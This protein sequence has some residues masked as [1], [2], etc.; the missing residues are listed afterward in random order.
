MIYENLVYGILFGIASFAYYKIHKW[1]LTGRDE[2]PLFYKPNTTIGTVNNWI[3]IIILGIASLVY[4]L[5]S[6]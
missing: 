4:L 2:N 1:W 5:K 3:I 6:F